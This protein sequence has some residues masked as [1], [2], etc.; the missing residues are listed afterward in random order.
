M[1]ITSQAAVVRE[2]H[3]RFD[4]LP[5]SVD[6]PQQGEVRVRVVAAGLC[7]SDHHLVTGDTVPPHLPMIGGH[8]G[9]GIVEA[10]GPNTPEWKVGDKLVF[11]WIPSCGTCVW[12]ASGRTNLCQLGRNLLLGT[13]FHNPESFRFTLEDGSVAGQMCGL[14]TFSEYTLVNVE[15]AI[16]V[17]DDADLN[18]LWLLG[19]GV[20]TGWG[21]AVYSAETKPGDVVVV[22]GIGGIGINAVQGAKHAGARA[23][24]AVDPV[25]FKRDAALRMGATHVFADIDE[26]AEFGRS[27]TDG[28]GAN[29]AIVT[30]GVLDGTH[31]AQAVQATGKDG[32]TVITSI[33]SDTVESIPISPVEFTRYQKR[34]QGTLYGHANPRADIPRQLEMYRSGQLVLDELITKTYTLDE[35]NQGYDDLLDGTLIRGRLTF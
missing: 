3:G 13:R 18:T 14:G 26:A 11:S 16:K 33:A 25:E 10:V 17:P 2:Q 9:S 5:V 27:I 31:V 15:S 19:C 22:M 20:G 21:S 8:E 23:I 1:P 35:I 7:H 12:C 34:I 29:R 6:D 32:V 28:Q 24:I 30:V 4:V